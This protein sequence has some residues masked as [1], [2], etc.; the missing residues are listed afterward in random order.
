MSDKMSDKEELPPSTLTFQPEYYI[1][2]DGLDKKN[3]PLVSQSEY[4]WP[5]DRVGYFHELLENATPVVIDKYGLRDAHPG[6]IPH[7]HRTTLLLLTLFVQ[8]LMAHE[9]DIVRLILECIIHNVRETPILRPIRFLFLPQYRSICR[10]V[11]GLPKSW[12]E[13]SIRDQVT[14]L[15]ERMTLD[16][17]VN[18]R[19][20]IVIPTPEVIHIVRPTINGYI[21]KNYEIILRFVPRGVF[22]ARMFVGHVI[23]D[24]LSLN[25]TEKLYY[26]TMLDSRIRGS[27]VPYFTDDMARVARK[28][29]FSKEVAKNVG[30]LLFGATCAKKYLRSDDA[31]RN[32]KIDMSIYNQ[33]LLVHQQKD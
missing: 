1:Y 33:I 29:G 21:S 12:C 32:A 16:D 19:H 2:S 22:P 8:R 9:P 24:E 5:V 31:W 6:R 30:K 23:Y 17:A 14:Y 10:L 7:T 20:G 13:L 15:S 4:R 25:E 11:A 28:A 3:N 27:I 26:Y 18:I